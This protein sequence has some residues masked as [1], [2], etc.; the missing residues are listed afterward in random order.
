MRARFDSKLTETEY[1]TKLQ[2]SY[3]LAQ[4]EHL[5]CDDK[6]MMIFC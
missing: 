6:K 3:S 5:M 4:E 1:V 2:K